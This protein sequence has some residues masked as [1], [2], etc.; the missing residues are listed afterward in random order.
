MI[1]EMSC[2]KTEEVENQVKNHYSI[3]DEIALKTIYEIRSILEN[4]CG[5]FSKYTIIDNPFH[6]LNEPVFTKDGFNIVKSLEFDHPVA[7]M[8]HKMVVYIGSKVA[9]HVGDGTTTGMLI[10]LNLLQEIICD[11]D[12]SNIFDLNTFNDIERFSNIIFSLI[13][14]K[15]ETNKVTVERLEKKLSSEG[16]TKEEIIKG[17]AYCQAF[18]SSHGDREIAEVISQMFAE[19]PEESLNNLNFMRSGYETP[20]KLK[21]LR[22]DFQYN[23]RSDILDT[24]FLNTEAGSKFYSEDV[25]VDLFNPTLVIES[26]ATTQIVQNIVDNFTNGNNYIVICTGACMQTRLRMKAI[27]RDLRTQ[28]DKDHPNDAYPA[29]GV[30]FVPIIETGINDIITIAHVGGL[31]SPTTQGINRLFGVT[32]E[33]ITGQIRFGNLYNEVSTIHP[34]LKP[35][36]KNPDHRYYNDYLNDLEQKIYQLKEQ[37]HNPAVSESLQ[38][39]IRLKNLMLLNKRVTVIIGGNSYDNSTLFD[40]VEDCINAV[41]KSLTKGFVPGG[42]LST[43][44]TLHCL[45]ELFSKNS[46]KGL[47]KYFNEEK[48]CY[49]FENQMLKLSEIPKIKLLIDWYLKATV[50]TSKSFINITEIGFTSDEAISY[51]VVSNQAV[52]LYSPSLWNTKLLSSYENVNVIIQP[53]DTDITIFRRIEEVVL[54]IAY[55][56][57]F[58]YRERGV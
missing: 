24:I 58:L 1:M 26:M 32:V 22:E 34:N 9:K 23:C 56:I 28:W 57:D 17:V 4:H 46:E 2:I 53:A 19:L 8:I 20:E 43:V 31:L 16:I 38:E 13:T 33:F 42:L 44:K 3:S 10:T 35:M 37:G 36:Y 6:E 41:K 54:K 15:L 39:Y 45:R 11:E 47:L 48:S 51:D 55:S 49:V 27:Y 40:I 12:I 5:P 25:T 7:K 21:I 50:E 30:F 29:H 52:F 14:N 18:T